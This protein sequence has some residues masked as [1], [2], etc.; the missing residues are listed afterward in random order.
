MSHLLTLRTERS[1]VPTAGVSLAGEQAR[2]AAS[3]RIDAMSCSGWNERSGCAP[4]DD[5]S[6]SAA[7][8]G[9][10]AVQRRPA[11]RGARRAAGASRPGAWP[12]TAC[13]AA[14]PRH[15]LGARRPSA[16]Q[17]T[18]KATGCVP[19]RTVRLAL[20]RAYSCRNG[21]LDVLRAPLRAD[22]GPSP[23]TPRAAPTLPSC[24]EGAVDVDDRR[25]VVGATAAC[26][27]AARRPHRRSRASDA[28]RSSTKRCELAPASV[29]C[30][31]APAAPAR[32]SGRRRRTGSSESLS[33]S[34]REQ[35]FAG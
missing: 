19:R 1:F 18:P 32:R 24:V 28:G 7:I 22:G 10:Q 12:L 15:A 5:S 8:Y 9:A 6:A 14:A 16:A 4:L 23:A 2:D 20:R 34:Q 25:E 33:C 21:V 27:H 35:R 13:R 29:R 31:R 17:T 3:W 26:S 11:R 30:R